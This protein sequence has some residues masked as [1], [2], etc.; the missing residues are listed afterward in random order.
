LDPPT[1]TEAVEWLLLTNMPTTTYAQALERARWYS[2]RWGIEVFH[3]TL[4]TGCRIEDRQLG[5]RARL[6]S[7]LAVD[8]VMAW[9]VYYLT[10][11]GR[12]DTELP[13]TVFFQDPEWKALYG[14]HHHT[15]ELPDKPP[16][17]RDAVR[18]IAM[19]GGFQGRKSDGHPGSEVLWHGLQKLDV[20]IEMYL[21]YRPNERH[22]MRS[23]YPPWY[24]R[25]D[26]GHDTG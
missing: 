6:E 3:R 10:M 24:L 2:A 21:I 14:W 8:L 11:M 17:L 16:S 4:K 7:C 20:A 25:P 15:T 5:Y 13:C 22:G 23:E 9:R 19:K 26:D 18:W 12:V 1:A